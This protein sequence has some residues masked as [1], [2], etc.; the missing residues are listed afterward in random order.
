VGVNG[1]PRPGDTYKT[2]NSG[3][4]TRRKTGGPYYNVSVT[5]DKHCLG[6]LER[7]QKGSRSEYIRWALKDY[8]L[9]GDDSQ[10]KIIA[11]LEQAI[12]NHLKIQ[13]KLGQRILDLEQK[14]DKMGII[15]RIKAFFF[16]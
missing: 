16:R 13:K 4:W 3:T 15:S 8:H 2:W 14:K 5:L 12:Q 1:L 7:Q 6:I 11:E 10:A 9:R